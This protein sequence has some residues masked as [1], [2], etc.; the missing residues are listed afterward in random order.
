MFPSIFA[1]PASYRA[2]LY[3]TISPI[4]V[5]PVLSGP[6]VD[7]DVLA[8]SLTTRMMPT[9]ISTYFALRTLRMQYD[10]CST[11]DPITCRQNWQQL[12]LLCAAVHYSVVYTSVG[13]SCPVSLLAVYFLTRRAV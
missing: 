2:Q 6:R 10:T 5:L 11:E 12:C 3:V 1:I 4:D 13:S 8:P 9:G 7:L